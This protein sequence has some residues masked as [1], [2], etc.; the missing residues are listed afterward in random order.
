MINNIRALKYK[1]PFCNNS[2]ESRL[3]K[4]FNIYC[5]GHKFSTD[6]L[7]T[8]RLNP[9]LGVGRIIKKIEIPASRSL[10]DDDTYVITKFKVKFDNIVR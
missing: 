2:L 7:V 9:E 10:D 1:C 5:Q 4:C 6:N 3:T 8:F